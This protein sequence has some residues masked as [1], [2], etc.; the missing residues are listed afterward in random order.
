MS[1]HRFRSSEGDEYGSFE[2]FYEDG[3]NSDFRDEEDQALPPGWYWWPCSV[4]C[5]P[6][7]MAFGPFDSEELALNDAHKDT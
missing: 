1:Y 5:M 6:E 4:G 7:S 2:V 3:S